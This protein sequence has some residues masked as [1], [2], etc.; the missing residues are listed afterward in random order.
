[1]KFISHQGSNPIFCVS[2]RRSLLFRF[3]IQKDIKKRKHNFKGELGQNSRE[4]VLQT[5]KSIKTLS[6]IF[7]EVLLVCIFN[8]IIL[9]QNIQKLRIFSQ[10]EVKN[11]IF[12][13]IKFN[14]YSMYLF[15]LFDYSS[16]NNSM[17]YSIYLIINV[18]FIKKKS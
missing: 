6:R 10:K 3:S 16:K 9:S 14:K 8:M 18:T 17:Y 5:T 1:M 13:K 4:R 11:I 15:H 7:G 12:V 2:F